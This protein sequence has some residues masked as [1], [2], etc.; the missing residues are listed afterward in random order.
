MGIPVNIISLYS[1]KTT[2][3]IAKATCDLSTDIK[4]I[5][6]GDL[7]L[8]NEAWNSNPQ[9]HNQKSQYNKA[10]NAI[11]N[12]NFSIITKRDQHTYFPYQANNKPSTID[13]IWNRGILPPSHIQEWVL[14]RPGPRFTFNQ[15]LLHQ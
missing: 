9:Y 4:A 1:P 3:H 6:V 14:L 13:L 11:L 12:Q 10:I 15:R 5:L 7:N 2:D 8:H